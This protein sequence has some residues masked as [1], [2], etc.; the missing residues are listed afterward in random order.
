[1]LVLERHVVKEFGIVELSQCVRRGEFDRPLEQRSGRFEIPLEF[2][3]I[4]E[5][6]QRDGIVGGQIDRRLEVTLRDV[7]PLRGE[8]ELPEP[9]R[10]L[11]RRQRSHRRFER[12]ELQ[13]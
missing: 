4:R 8:R 13:R 6:G 10:D 1:M 5:T 12:R 2:G 3:R 11:E 9:N 7:T